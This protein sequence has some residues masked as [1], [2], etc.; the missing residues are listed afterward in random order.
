MA[1]QS[2]TDI[3]QAC[4]AITSLALSKPSGISNDDLQQG[5][6]NLSAEFRVKAI[7]KLLQMEKLEVLK[8]GNTLIYR[9]KDQSKI[10]QINSLGI[11]LKSSLVS[12][13]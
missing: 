6:P 2:I 7:N 3:D 1:E 12:K 8:K 4:S 13:I 10:A 5:V 9:L 11:T